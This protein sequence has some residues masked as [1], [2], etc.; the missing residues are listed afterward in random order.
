MR[1]ILSDHNIE[2]HLNALIAFWESGPLREFWD[3]LDLSV[4]TFESLGIPTDIADSTLWQI[5]Q[6]R[7]IILFTANR[8]NDGPD[9]LEATIR[10][11]GLVTSLPVLTLANVFRFANDRAYAAEVA[12]RAIERLMDI[13]DLRGSGRIYI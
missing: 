2:G 1:G 5:C 11:Q 10:Q 12:K 3:D 9:S 13:E 4:E 8:N 6:N 7:E